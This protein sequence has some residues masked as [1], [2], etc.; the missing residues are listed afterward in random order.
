MPRSCRYAVVALAVLAA[1]RDSSGP[2]CSLNGVALSQAAF[3]MVVGQSV[4]VAAEI[5]QRGCR[6]L[7]AVEWSSSDVSVASVSSTGVVAAIGVG[8]TTITARLRG[9]A[10]QASAQVAVKGRVLGITVEPTTVQLP[11]TGT[12]QLAATVMADPGTPTT[13]RWASSDPTRATVSPTGLVTGVASG[14]AT[15][16]ATVEQ[17]T[18]RRASVPI[19]IFARVTGMQ[20]SPERVRLHVTETRQ[21]AAAVSGDSGIATGVMWRSANPAIAT[22]GSGGL[23]TALAAGETQVTAVAA[24]DTTRQA[25][26]TIT[27]IPRVAS[28]AVTPASASLLVTGTL[29]LS[30]M[31]SGDA[32]VDTAVTWSSAD[33]TRATVS[34]SGLV[35]GMAAG[36]TVVTVRA[37]ADSSKL[38]TAAVTILPRVTGVAVSP[39]T[40]SVSVGGTLALVGQVQGDS[41]VSQQ[42]MWRS[43][44][45]SR[46]SVSATG[47]VTGVGL[48]SATITAL[49]AADTSRQASVTMTIQAR[50]TAVTVTPSSAAINVGNA[51]QL[52]ATVTGDPGVN[53][54][55][56]WSSSDPS[57]ATVNASGLVT[58]IAAGSVTVTATS[59]VSSERK[60]TAQVTV[61]LPAAALSC[62]V[63]G[64]TAPGPEG[65]AAPANAGCLSAG[66][67]INTV[68][69]LG[70]KDANGQVVAATITSSHPTILLV[71][72]QTQPTWVLVL[73]VGSGSVTLTA[74]TS[75][76]ALSVLVTA[77]PGGGGGGQKAPPRKPEHIP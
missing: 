68:G 3:E 38:A 18:T 36:A 30:A 55:V 60:G 75:R 69:F 28:I 62:I 57:R 19:T 77:E 11:V 34:A 25:R 73:P 7:P 56:T 51:V 37:R 26:S 54:A 20:V 50:V 71:P 22:V 21:L 6:E 32:G 27:V 47:V 2:A 12:R 31:V 9:R 13:L 70:V 1:C 58:G 42:L 44:D 35:T 49:A 24:A 33:A 8:N 53:T 40:G 52:L 41:G 72:P 17:D 65:A 48:G 63:M 59:V 15:I 67:V 4:A 14:S 23:V 45:P 39:A 29:Q 5:S 76:G 61:T 66:S 46:A 74:S 64:P 16:T 43:S 10:D